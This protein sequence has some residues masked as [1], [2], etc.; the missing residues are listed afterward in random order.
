MSQDYDP[1]I[2]HTICDIYVCRN[3]PDGWWPLQHFLPLAMPAGKRMVQIIVL[4]LQLRHAEVTS[5][6]NST[7][8][9]SGKDHLTTASCV[10]Y[11]S[12]PVIGQS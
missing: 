9:K 11:K 3:C 6:A 4:M 5:N 7:A 10:D 8:N 2:C 12:C 1:Q